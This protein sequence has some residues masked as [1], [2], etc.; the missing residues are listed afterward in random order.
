VNAIRAKLIVAGVVL[1]GAV[2]Y[3]ALAGVKSGWVY[4]V[5]VEQYLSDPQFATQRVRVHGVV[6]AEQFANNPARLTASFLLKGRDGGAVIIAYRGNVPEMF[7]PGKNVV[8]EGR[9]DPAG[10]F[11]AD[12]LMTKCASKYEPGSPH[13]AE[14]AEV[15][16]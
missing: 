13:K 9:R 5:D 6:G 11:Q 1:A 3:L 12:V 4:M 7:G 2:G 16:R 10:V 15:A 14:H 8:V